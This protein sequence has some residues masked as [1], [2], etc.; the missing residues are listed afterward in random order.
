MASIREMGVRV[1]YVAQFFLLLVIGLL[2]GW[3]I[4]GVL[5]EFLVFMFLKRLPSEAPYWIFQY[6]GYSR[7]LIAQ[8]PETIHLVGNISWSLAFVGTL[9]HGQNHFREI[10]RI[11]LLHRM[12]YYSIRGIY[13]EPINTFEDYSWAIIYCLAE[14]LVPTSVFFIVFFSILNMLEMNYFIAIFIGLIAA[15]LSVNK[16]GE[17]VFFALYPHRIQSEIENSPHV[18]RVMNDRLEEL[19]R[20]KDK[21]MK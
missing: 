2:I 1:S 9:L 18:L 8:K 17:F 4:G 5:T 21:D 11:K 20:L 12:M 3:N 14:T 19:R 16:A 15:A 13:S 10:L 6:L 7:D